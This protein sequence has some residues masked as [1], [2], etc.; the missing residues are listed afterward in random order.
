MLPNGRTGL[1]LTDL[2]QKPS[3]NPFAKPA[4]GKTPFGAQYAAVRP[5]ARLLPCL[6][7]AAR[8]AAPK[9]RGA[10]SAAFA[11]A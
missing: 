2:K 8:L 7:S 1:K 11:R 10:L 9:L 5:R 3:A 4:D 6:S